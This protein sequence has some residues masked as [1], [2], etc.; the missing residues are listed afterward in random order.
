MTKC[1]RAKRLKGLRNQF[2]WIHHGPPS[3]SAP[4][5]RSL[6][7]MKISKAKIMLKIARNSKNSSPIMSIGCYCDRLAGSGTLRK[8]VF[9]ITYDTNGSTIESPDRKESWR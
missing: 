3:R 2:S 1:C 9:K 8:F 6:Y 7:R 5:T 4:E